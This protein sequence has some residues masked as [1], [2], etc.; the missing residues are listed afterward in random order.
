M[1]EAVAS[2]SGG[3]LIRIETILGGAWLDHAFFKS[4]NVSMVGVQ[5]ARGDGF[6]VM[7]SLMPIGFGRSV[8]DDQAR[9]L[10]VDAVQSVSDV[11][12]K[13]HRDD[14]EK[15]GRR[16][17]AHTLLDLQKRLFVETDIG[18]RTFRGK[19][20]REA[21]LH[22]ANAEHVEVMSV[23]VVVV[24]GRLRAA[25]AGHEQRASNSEGRADEHERNIL[26]WP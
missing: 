7:N 11:I 10:E 5:V 22:P 3:F 20:G 4:S 8:N 17:N 15:R 2:V 14:D 19:C 18:E 12:G 23:P 1:S 24:L 13:A 6:Q 25:A 21:Q 26:Q 9:S 16:G